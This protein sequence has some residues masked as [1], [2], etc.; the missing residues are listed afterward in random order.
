MPNENEHQQI[1]YPAS[2]FLNTFDDV[3]FTFRVSHFNSY[4]LCKAYLSAKGDFSI[5]TLIRSIGLRPHFDCPLYYLTMNIPLIRVYLNV[6][7]LML[8]I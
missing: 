4:M 6:A 7:N 8:L 5:L 2:T 3:F 1:V